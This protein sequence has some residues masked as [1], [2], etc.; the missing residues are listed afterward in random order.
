[1][2]NIIKLTGARNN[3]KIYINK[4]HI[5]SFWR[6]YETFANGIKENIEATHIVLSHCVKDGKF[7]TGYIV[8]E[9]PETIE[10]M[11]NVY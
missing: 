6:V 10:N 4:N 8:K 3:S 2:S 5:V 9:T 1:M 11:M 7:E